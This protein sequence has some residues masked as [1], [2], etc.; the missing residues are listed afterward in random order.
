MKWLL[1]A[2]IHLYRRLP[3]R[4]KRKCLFKETCS[5]HVL[6]M[7]RQSGLRA[8]VR[9]LMLRVSQCRAGYAVLFDGDLKH[10]VVRFANGSVGG[11]DEVADFVLAPYKRFSIRNYEQL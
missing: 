3:P 8:G 1:I 5:S 7:T 10:W 11:R 6:R 9:N 2:V 4:F